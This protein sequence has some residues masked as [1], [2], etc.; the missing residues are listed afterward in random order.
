MGQ[1]LTAIPTATYARH[2]VCLQGGTQFRPR[3]G[4]HAE[5]GTVTRFMATC[6]PKYRLHSSIGLTYR[7]WL[8]TD[9]P[10]PEQGVVVQAKRLHVA[11]KNNN[12]TGDQRAA[13]RLGRES[14]P[15][16]AR[17]RVSNDVARAS[18][19]TSILKG[20]RVVASNEGPPALQ[21]EKRTGAPPDRC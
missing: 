9:S 8:S 21:E 1:R 17:G 2:A 10:N 13:C 6:G 20:S 7:L 12:Q 15:T 16:V 3:T 4:G 5:A 11:A 18:L 14:R 19:Y